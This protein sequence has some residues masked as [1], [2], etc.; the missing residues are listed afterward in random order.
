[1][2][3]KKDRPQ[4]PAL[5]A[6][7]PYGV[8]Y[9]H[10]GQMQA[11]DVNNEGET[12]RNFPAH[13]AAPMAWGNYQMPYPYYPH[14]SH[15]HYQQPDYPHPQSQQ[16]PLEAEDNP[17]SMSER[18]DDS[19]GFFE[20][21]PMSERTDDLW[22]NGV[23]DLWSQVQALEEERKSKIK[24][25]AYRKAK[26]RLK[27]AVREV[28]MP[29]EV[30][31]PSQVATHRIQSLH[32]ITNKNIQKRK[33]RIQS[34]KAKLDALEQANNVEMEV[35]QDVKQNYI[36]EFTDRFG[37][38]PA[39]SR[40]TN[41]TPQ[42][43]AFGVGDAT[44]HGD[45]TGKPLADSCSD[46]ENN[47][48]T[49]KLH[50]MIEQS[51]PFGP[52][53]SS[54]RTILVLLSYVLIEHDSEILGVRMNDMVHLNV[55]EQGEVCGTHVSRRGHGRRQETK[56]CAGAGCCAVGAGRGSCFRAF[57]ASKAA[58]TRL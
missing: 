2:E 54:L 10:W 31:V 16:P 47:K 8:P 52:I 12:T 45:D 26:Y 5:Q 20:P 48:F 57:S 13:A 15:P 36:E 3:E 35:L 33:K 18:T 4:I 14:Y 1:M 6:V 50:D 30:A 28:R 37:P 9:T 46:L 38:W 32:A 19:R 55:R 49:E 24:T 56:G 17:T 11:A 7:P 43:D 39:S 40:A 58:F 22:R 42:G 21:T 29:V 44:P 53:L 25:L 34:L 51:Y 41:T 23:T 27:K